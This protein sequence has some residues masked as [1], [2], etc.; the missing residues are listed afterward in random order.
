M[1]AKKICLMS[2][3]SSTGGLKGIDGRMLTEAENK[4]VLVLNLSKKTKGES[5]ERKN[6]LGRYFSGL[7]ADQV[8]FITH[9]RGEFRL[10]NFFF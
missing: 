3:H 1:S 2:G 5:E 8:D 4:N 7:G 10:L 9:S 6:F